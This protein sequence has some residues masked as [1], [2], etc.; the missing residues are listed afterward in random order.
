MQSSFG[1]RIPFLQAGI[2]GCCLMVSAMYVSPPPAMA[3]SGPFAEFAG[4]WSGNGTLRPENGASERIRCNATYRPGG[5]TQRDVELQ[6]R[7]ASDSYNF[8][9]S[10]QFSADEQNQVSGRWT[11]RS[12]STGGTA[13]GMAQGDRLQLHIESAGFAA[14]VVMVTRNRRQS[15]DIDSHGAGQIVKATITLNRS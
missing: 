11:E 9:L 3:E 15:V 2:L 4:S 8:D 13:V 1:L 10:G 7:C 12:R 5:R 6:L 14:D